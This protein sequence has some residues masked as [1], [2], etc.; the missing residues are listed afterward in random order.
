[1]TEIDSTKQLQ[2]RNISVTLLCYYSAISGALEIAHL[3]NAFV[4]SEITAHYPENGCKVH[5]V[6]LHISEIQFQS[7]MLLRKNIYE[8]VAYLHSE[9][10][11]HFLAHP[12]YAQN[13]KLK[14]IT[15]YFTLIHSRLHMKKILHVPAPDYNQ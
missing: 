12:L 1:L 15:P 3:E 8:L 10:I 9:K 7:I 13:E 5:V 6:V 11:V 14:L 4:S 2:N